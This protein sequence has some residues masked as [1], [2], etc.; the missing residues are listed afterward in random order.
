MK[1]IKKAED[2]LSSTTVFRYIFGVIL[3]LVETFKKLIMSV[4]KHITGLLMVFAFIGMIAAASA[5]ENKAINYTT[6]I[7]F[8]LILAILIATL[9]KIKILETRGGKN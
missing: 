2:K 5:F 9:I 4:I 3:F 6:A 1:Y 7:L 8:I